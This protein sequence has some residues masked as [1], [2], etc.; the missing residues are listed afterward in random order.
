ML[1]NNHNA[2]LMIQLVAGKVYPLCGIMGL[3]Y[4]PQPQIPFG[5]EL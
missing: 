3:E 2:V 4:L 5:K 1:E